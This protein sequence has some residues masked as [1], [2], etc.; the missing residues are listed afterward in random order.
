MKGKMG[1]KPVVDGR[2]KIFLIMSS[3]ICNIIIN[4]NQHTDQVPWP[5]GENVMLTGLSSVTGS[6]LN[7]I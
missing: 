1:F 3:Y 4:N 6:G 7:G 5:L 2:S